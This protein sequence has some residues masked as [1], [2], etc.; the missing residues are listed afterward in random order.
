MP[1]SSHQLEESAERRSRG[2]A[3]MDSTKVPESMALSRLLYKVEQLP[4]REGAWG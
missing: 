4:M 2:S 1:I 3:V